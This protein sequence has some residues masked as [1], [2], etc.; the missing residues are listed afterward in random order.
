MEKDFKVNDLII[1]NELAGDKAGMVGEVFDKVGTVLGL[2][3]Y[4]QETETV[5]PYFVEPVEVEHLAINTT[6][7]LNDIFKTI[8]ELNEFDFINIDIV[9]FPEQEAIRIA[10]DF[11][12]STEPQIIASYYNPIKERDMKQDV[13]GFEK[14]IDMLMILLSLKEN[15]YKTIDEFE[16]GEQLFEEI[17]F[18]EEDDDDDDFDEWFDNDEY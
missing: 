9:M 17:E 7:V 13:P 12:E 1:L 10:V 18:D 4:N 8:K 6:K 16:A 11:L 2:R 15:I 3:L 5:E 14:L